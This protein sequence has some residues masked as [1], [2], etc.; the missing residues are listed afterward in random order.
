MNTHK[1]T[2]INSPENR[3]YIFDTTLR[4]G[5]QSP[6]AGM[7]FADNLQYAAYADLLKVDILEAGFPS[8]SH[9]D[10]DIV[11]AISKQ[12]A[13]KNSA[14]TIAALCQLREEQFIKTMEAL[15][16]RLAQGKAR[17]HTYVPVDPQ[18]MPASLGHLSHDKNKIIDEVYRLIRLATQA[19]FE[20]E[21]SPEGYSQLGIHFD[22]VTDLIRAAVNAGA[23]IINCPDTIGGAARIQGKHYFVNHMK[24][25]AKIIAQ[26]FKNKKIIWSTHCHNDFGLA[27]DN[28]INAV[29][30]GPA[31]QIEGCING[32]GERA[33]NVA[34]EQCI[35]YIKQFGHETA[36]HTHAPYYTAIDFQ[37]LKKISD[38]IAEKMLSRQPHY[39][40]VGD[41]ATRHSSGGHT[42]AILKNPLAY[43]PF[44]PEDIGGKIDFVFGPL[45]GSNHA[46]K[47]IEKH[48]YRCETA[49]KTLITQAIK[50]YYADRRKGITDDE[51]IKGYWHF[52]AP[53]KIKTISSAKI[54]AEETCLVLS[55]QFF[56]SEKI[57]IPYPEETASDKRITHTLAALAK[58]IAT[59]FPGVE[60][61]EHR[62]HACEEAA[63]NAK[64]HSTIRIK[65]P[66]KIN[67][68]HEYTGIAIAAESEISALHAF[69]NA[70]NHAYIEMHYRLLD[71]NPTIHPTFN[72][73][74]NTHNMILRQE[75]V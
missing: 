10:F 11:H 48:G 17:V 3:I 28:S 39:P 46:K 5:Q 42:N 58:K 66:L 68:Y 23:T 47:I 69:I 19:G 67:E 1:N 50:Q 8:A 24:K 41:N 45:S 71:T 65:A 15:M 20:V 4:D 62:S 32:V 40:I 49:E 75:H 59:F 18:L 38:F 6:G 30:N 53:I 33:G 55:G 36:M 9:T 74:V 61:I 73:P 35:M 43:Q 56:D 29:F 14:M 12:M 70:V 57:A 72:Q 16:P 31:R 63:V 26:E 25:H 7:S 52:R 34:L 13:D 51:L 21:F 54:N 44:D 22:F 37:H 60:I 27:L 64:Y 2:Q